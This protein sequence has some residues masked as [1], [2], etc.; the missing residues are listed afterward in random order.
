MCVATVNWTLL[1][2]ISSPAEY[3]MLNSTIGYTSFAS[4]TPAQSRSKST[5]SGFRFFTLQTRVARIKLAGIPIAKIAGEV[6]PP[7]AIGEKFRVH[8][9]NKSTHRRFP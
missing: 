7:L 5:C 3:V 1:T 9:E 4:I 2:D 6:D 8:F